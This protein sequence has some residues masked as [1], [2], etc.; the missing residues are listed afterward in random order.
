M[1]TQVIHH[2]CVHGFGP[3]E[4]CHHKGIAETPDHRLGVARRYLDQQIGRSE[5][6]AM[7]DAE[8][9]SA[10]LTEKIG[11]Y[12]NLFLILSP[13]RI[14]LLTWQERVGIIENAI[15]ETVTGGER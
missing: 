10:W 13:G 12:H 15:R 5:C 7:L 14:G 8:L 9:E 4:E 11:G 1:V 2:G 3:C 6:M